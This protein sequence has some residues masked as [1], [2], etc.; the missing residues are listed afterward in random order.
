[1]DPF[2]VDSPKVKTTFYKIIGRQRNFQPC[3]WGWIN[4]RTF[5]I[6][7]SGDD[8]QLLTTEQ[9]NQLKKI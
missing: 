9:S 2:A 5:I 8:D 6:C 3:G 4:R 7:L 1:M